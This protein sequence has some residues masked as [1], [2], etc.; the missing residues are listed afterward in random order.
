MQDLLMRFIN[1]L[2][3]SLKKFQ[4]IYSDTAGFG[5]LTIHQLQYLETI[6]TLGIPTITDIAE[7]LS[8]S[9]ASVTAGVNKLVSLG[10]VTKKRSQED[11]R[12]VHV[13]LTENALPLIAAKQETLTMYEEFIRG[14]L[15]EQEFTQFTT[16]LAKLVDV[17]EH[18]AVFTEG[19][20]P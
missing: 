17:F 6:Y 15:S 3:D 10:Y 16:I 5:S 14:A 2:D 20:Q 18:N 19:K 4:V 12:V 7:A 8:F 11:R 9:K 13:H 1:T